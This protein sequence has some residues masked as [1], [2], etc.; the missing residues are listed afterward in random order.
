M[1]ANPATTRRIWGEICIHYIAAW[2]YFYV[3]CVI[4]LTV[5][6]C[7]T[8]LM[9]GEFNFDINTV[10]YFWSSSGERE[11]ERERER[12]DQI[13]KYFTN[14]QSVCRI[15]VRILIQNEVL[16]SVLTIYIDLHITFILI[17]KMIF[18]LNHSTCR[19]W[20]IFPNILEWIKWLEF[21]IF[22]SLL[23]TAIYTNDSKHH[24]P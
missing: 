22:V 12:M 24:V 9:S 6:D 10:C 23:Y 20:R 17:Y 8:I 19:F 3:T 5:S 21:V 11:R 16:W 14:D 2:V 1:D 13:S 4:W 7:V 15:S 18:I